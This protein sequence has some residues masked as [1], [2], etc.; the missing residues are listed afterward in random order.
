MSGYRNIM[1]LARALRITLKR[2]LKK[3]TNQ[4]EQ[5]IFDVF[6]LMVND[7]C[8]VCMWVMFTQMHVMYSIVGSLS[9]FLFQVDPILAY[10]FLFLLLG[11]HK[12]LLAR[13]RH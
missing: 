9:V 13:K 2:K 10:L 5:L 12:K 4:K 3:R 7:L 11:R 6:A 1:P 8:D